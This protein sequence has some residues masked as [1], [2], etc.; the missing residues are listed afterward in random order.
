MKKIQ[1]KIDGEWRDVWSLRVMSDD[2]TETEAYT[3]SQL[4][5]IKTE[6][7][8]TAGWCQNCG[9]IHGNPFEDG[10]I[11]LIND[12]D[13]CEHDWRLS[14][15]LSGVVKKPKKIEISDDVKEYPDWDDVIDNRVLIRE[16]QR[17]VNLLNG[18]KKD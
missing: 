6:E 18:K 14:G 12:K 2:R 4:E 11:G 1:V 13:E 10:R 5:D 16:L 7:C 17:E 15:G 8:L 9:E 3:P